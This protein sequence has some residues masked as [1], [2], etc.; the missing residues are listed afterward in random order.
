MF[1]GLTLF[2]IQACDRIYRVGQTRDV[3]IHRFL[4]EDT[5]EK[6]IIDL[7]QKKLNMADTVLTGA[8]HLQ[9][10]KLSLEDL[11][12]LFGLNMKKAK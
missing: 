7:Q 8:K 11:K 5:V 4:C 6:R 1:V 12:D 3:T 2:W 9:S 10:N